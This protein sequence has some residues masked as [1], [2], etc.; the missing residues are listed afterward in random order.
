MDVELQSLEG[1]FNSLIFQAN[2]IISDIRPGKL[3]GVFQYQDYSGQTIAIYRAYDDA[4][5]IFNRVMNKRG[6]EVSLDAGA[7][8]ALISN[9][10]VL[11]MLKSIVINSH[12]A[13]SAIK[14]LVSTLPIEQSKELE[15]L[16]DELEKMSSSIS[17][18][19]CVKNLRGAMEEYESAHYLASSLIS[20]RVVLFCL[21]EMGK[22]T[23]EIVTNLKEK[24]ILKERGVETE[25]FIIKANRKARAYFT[26]DINVFPD[27]S[28]SIS[29]LGDA[30]KILK[31]AIKAKS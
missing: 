9:D 30:V 28:D 7:S 23:K 10:S 13:L 14:S 8:V 31:I 6:L 16:K 12:K 15:S 17:N 19:N 1:E 21:Q 11:T 4:R 3:G 24:G 29:L 25:E 2:D 18:I 22:D 20:G 27:P 26:H 5:K